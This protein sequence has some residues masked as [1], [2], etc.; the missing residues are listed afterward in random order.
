MPNGESF[1][2]EGKTYGLITKEKIGD[3]SFGYDCI[4]WSDK[5]RKTFGQAKKEEKASV[6]H[7]IMAMEKVA[8]YLQNVG[9]VS[10]EDE[11][12]Y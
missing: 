3:E 6:S 5:L 11:E 12:E 7:R 10:S 9:Y 8:G 4:F 1:V 2:A